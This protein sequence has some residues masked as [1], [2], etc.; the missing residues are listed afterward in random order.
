M[1]GLPKKEVELTMEKPPKS[2]SS[3]TTAGGQST[4]Y[5]LTASS[6]CS[7]SSSSSANLTYSDFWARPG[8]ISL[9]KSSIDP[10]EEESEGLSDIPRE[11]FSEGESPLRILRELSDG[12]N[13]RFRSSAT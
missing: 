13:W 5:T 2:A 8:I 3:S 6:L 4:K 7:N 12:M 11:D 10:E 1:I 9:S